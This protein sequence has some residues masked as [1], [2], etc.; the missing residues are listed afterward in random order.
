VAYMLSNGPNR[1]KAEGKGS[2]EKVL[3]Q[4]S[5]PLRLTVTLR[6]LVMSKRS[7]CGATALGDDRVEEVGAKPDAMRVS[8]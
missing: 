8:G 5:G 2:Q 4:K 3:I 1:A 6:S 7:D